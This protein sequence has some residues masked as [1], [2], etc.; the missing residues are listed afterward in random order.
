MLGGKG[1][2]SLSNSQCQGRPG[3]PPHRPSCPQLALSALSL[4]ISHVFLAWERVALAQALLGPH[5]DIPTY[6]AFASCQERSLSKITEPAGLSQTQRTTFKSRSGKPTGRSWSGV[7]GGMPKVSV[8]F[9]PTSLSR[10]KSITCN[11]T[12]E[13]PSVQ[14]GPI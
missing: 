9:P 11:R 3:A 5:P 12:P 7:A 10:T 6:L 4:D 13:A 2:E 14:E 8:S 1:Q